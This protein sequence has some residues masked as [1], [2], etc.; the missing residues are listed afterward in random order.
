MANKQQE[1]SAGKPAK[2]RVSRK[3]PSTTVA[4]QTHGAVAPK[5]TNMN[6][7]FGIKSSYTAQTI[8]QYREQLNGYTV[9]DLHAHA[10]QVDVIPLDPREKLVSAL[11]RKFMEIQSKALPLQVVPVKPNKE[12]LEFHRKF[13]QGSL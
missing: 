7:L 12:L 3:T 11:E 4:H 13:M 6:E 5:V 9:T 10:H 1:S 2:K 8:A